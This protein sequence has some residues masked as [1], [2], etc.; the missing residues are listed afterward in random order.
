[1]EINTVSVISGEKTKEAA[2]H[3]GEKIKQ[4]AQTAAK[5]MKDASNIYLFFCSVYHNKLC[6]S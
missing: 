6:T 4:S 3:A 1:M 5:V 2:Q